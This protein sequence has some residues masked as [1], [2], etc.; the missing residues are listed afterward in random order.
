VRLG[1]AEI[2]VLKALM[3]NEVSRAS[4]Q[5]RVRLELLGL[6]VDS[7]TGLRLTATGLNAA[8]NILP[9]PLEEHDLPPRRFDAL[10]RRKMHGR[11]MPGA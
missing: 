2:E 1:T 9:T 10:G 6:V 3:R 7:A 8:L 4:S 11:V 5:Q